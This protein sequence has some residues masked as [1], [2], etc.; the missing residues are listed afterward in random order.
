[1]I[2]ERD[3]GPMVEFEKLTPKQI[4]DAAGVSQ[5][6]VTAVIE[7]NNGLIVAVKPLLAKLHATDP[8]AANAIGEEFATWS[9]WLNEAMRAHDKLLA[10]IVSGAPSA[11]KLN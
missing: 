6:L 7:G 8:D 3:K 2:N 10:A 9:A 4:F 5:Q 11:D 1:M